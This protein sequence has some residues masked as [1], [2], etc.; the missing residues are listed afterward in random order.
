VLDSFPLHANLLRS[1]LQSF[2]RPVAAGAGAV[3]SLLDVFSLF[4][5]LSELDS[6]LVFDPDS[7]LD[8]EPD[9]DPDSEL[10]V[11][12]DFDPDS[13]LDVEPDVDCDSELDGEPD[14]ESLSFDAP[15]SFPLPDPGFG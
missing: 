12:P 4:D 11:E 15:S 6:E 3:F 9:F 10:D 2:L 14:A 7:E 5:A 1:L 13:E 8:V